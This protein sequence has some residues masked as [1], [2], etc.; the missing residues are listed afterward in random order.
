MIL[1]TRHIPTSIL[2]TCRTVYEEANDIIQGLIR[3]FVLSRQP[4]MIIKLWTAMALTQR[5]MAA[6]G[7]ALAN[8]EVW[9]YAVSGL[10]CGRGERHN[11]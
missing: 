4:K 9:L 7:Y 10:Y 2:A 11:I 1:I 3:S 6:V 8:L 5:I